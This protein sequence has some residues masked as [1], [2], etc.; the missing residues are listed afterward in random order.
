MEKTETK[1]ELQE[2]AFDFNVYLHNKAIKESHWSTCGVICGRV[3]FHINDNIEPEKNGK[4]EFEPTPLDDTFLTALGD[5]NA[6][7]TTFDYNTIVVARDYLNAVINKYEEMNIDKIK[8]QN[9]K[10]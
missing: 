6:G 7:G 2:N 4:I 8:N 3:L 10:K 5:N 9:I 1:V